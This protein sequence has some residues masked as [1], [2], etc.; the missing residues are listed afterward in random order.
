MVA[1]E[2]I[3]AS[4]RHTQKNKDFLLGRLDQVNASNSFQA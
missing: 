3:H 4:R 2:I 1:I